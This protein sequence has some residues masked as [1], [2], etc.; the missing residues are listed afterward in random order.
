MV[1]Q[2]HH[3]SGL[4]MGAKLLRALP[5]DQFARYSSLTRLLLSPTIFDGFAGGV[6]QAATDLD[7]VLNNQKVGLS[8]VDFVRDFT[9]RMWNENAWS[10]IDKMMR[11]TEHTLVSVCATVNR[12]YLG[13]LLQTGNF[14]K[15]FLAASVIVQAAPACHFSTVVLPKEVLPRGTAMALDWA[16][17]SLEDLTASFDL[18]VAQALVRTASAMLL[19]APLLLEAEQLEEASRLLQALVRHVP[20]AAAGAVL[21]QTVDDLYA[22]GAPLADDEPVKV[23]KKVLKMKLGQ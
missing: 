18:T 13:S 9:A 1:M 8:Q 10:R 4:A 19:R 12:V 11:K 5:D 22:L 21:K 7:F 2:H 16:H 14:A 15:F 3:L 17:L 23:F 6:G 20:D